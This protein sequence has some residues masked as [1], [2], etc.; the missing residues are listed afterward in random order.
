[1]EDTTPFFFLCFL[2]LPFAIN[3]CFFILFYFSTSHLLNQNHLPRVLVS[4]VSNAKHL[5]F[6]TLR[7]KTLLQQ[8][9]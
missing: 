2:P 1:M 3:V 7:P 9:F 6:G 4:S 8:M 5:T